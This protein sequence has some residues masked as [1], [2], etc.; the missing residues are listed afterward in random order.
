M[1][2]VA[3]GMSQPGF[4]I[5]ADHTSLCLA[6]GAS[7][8]QNLAV[9]VFACAVF[10]RHTFQEMNTEEEEAGEGMRYMETKS[11]GLA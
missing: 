9:T 10:A 2:S 11:L 6:N 1:S 8:G 7:Q 3:G 5:S 4:R